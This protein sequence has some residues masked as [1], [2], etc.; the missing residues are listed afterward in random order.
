MKV[1]IVI[2]VYNTEK[3]LEKCV[4]SIQCQ[5]HR[6]LQ[7]ILVNDASEDKSL[8]LMKKLAQEDDRI[9]ILDEPHAGLSATR[10]AGMEVIDGDYV[11][12]V[13][14]DD[15]IAPD[16]YE[17]MLSIIKECNAD[18]AYCEWTEEYADGSSDAK[19]YN[20]TKKMLLQGDEILQ[21]FFDESIHLRI[22]SGLLS[23]SIIE[24]LRFDTNLQPG[25]EMYFGFRTL[26]NAKRIVYINE[27]FYHR[28]NRLGSISNQTCFHETEIRRATSADMR[29]AYVKENYPQHLGPAYNHCIKYYETVLNYMIYFGEE[30]HNKIMY[31]KLVSRLDELV[32]EL[33]KPGKTLELPVWMAYSVFHKCFGVYR[34]IVFVYYR[35]IK[36][37]FGGKRQK[38]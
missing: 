25:E 21:T 2:P 33:D 29:L 27:P 15:W 11:S 38:G 1:S 23:R 32:A 35:F 16:M 18:A 31:T 19:N 9:C 12:F 13:D 10:N 22:S 14:S 34:L 3:Y 37:E 28:Y 26:C 36:R 17:R 5:T 20:G 6:D 7:I 4:K 30:K 24:N 8:D